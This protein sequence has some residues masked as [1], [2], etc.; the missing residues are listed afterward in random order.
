MKHPPTRQRRTIFL[1]ST[2][3]LASIA[4]AVVV[5]SATMQYRQA[6]R[7]R[8]EQLVET[9]KVHARLI[10]A[11]SRHGE[12]NRNTIRS[13]DA[14]AATLSQIIDAH[15]HYRGFGRTGEF[16]LGQR[17]GNRIVFLLRHRHPDGDEPLVIP[18][19][20]ENAQ[21]MRYALSGRAGTLVGLDYRGNR[22][23]A[24]YEPVEG[25]GLGVVAKIDTREVRAPFV[26]AGIVT[27][28]IAVL[29]IAVGSFC[30][31][32]IADPMV[33]GIEASEAKQRAVRKRTEK[34][35]KRAH[36]EL[37]LIFDAADPLCVIDKKLG[38][39]R[40]NDPF[41]ELFGVRR[42]EVLGRKCCEIWQ[43]AKC[44]TKR[45]A[46]KRITAGQQRVDYEV[47]QPRA[48]G[49]VVSCAVT[50]IPY[51]DPGGELLGIVK[52]FVDITQR[53]Q[54][55]EQLKEKNKDLETL[56]Y[57][58]SHDL[59]EPLRTIQ[60]FAE[61][62]DS[63]YADRL[64]RKG[65]DFLSRI[66]RGAKRLDRL[67]A[68]ILTLSRAQ[69]MVTPSEWVDA[70]EIV[71]DVLQRLE[72]KILE[73]RAMVF[74]TGELP[75]LFVDRI[76]ATQAIYNL[77]A[78][79]LKFTRDGESP[80]VEIEAVEIDTYCPETSDSVQA[81]PVQGIVIRDCGPGILPEYRERV[82]ELFQRAVG[83]DVEGTG[84][85]LAIVRQIARRH[86]GDV[87]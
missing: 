56:F 19:N 25:I 72:T 29:M 64:D 75:R 36:Y 60:N 74:V 45:C 20:S 44:H 27:G 79:A 52:N 17:E 37:Q 61:L 14:R 87:R 18:W 34:A 7:Q 46:L 76:W 35:L 85:G 71:D 39:S 68:D 51:R 83:R 33:R 26:E 23:L 5:L 55:E 12:L 48:D 6:F 82:F 28:T 86:G 81:A 58:T 2:L 9:V 80:I 21:P 57:V 63:R 67:V 31:F 77:V 65:R 3:I 66:I 22:V 49:S 42:E 1:A 10:E 43:S 62:V 59:R 4:L 38:I 54:A 30:F 73:S 69:R 11:V 53:K 41:C 13:A 78:N 24:A 32:Q 84:A 16:V 70:A 47:D 40:V 50:A 8:R 15:E